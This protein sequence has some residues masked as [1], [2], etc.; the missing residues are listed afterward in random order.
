VKRSVPTLFPLYFFVILQSNLS[1]T[2][3]VQLME[4]NPYGQLQRLTLYIG[5]QVILEFGKIKCCFGFTKRL[6]RGGLG[7]K[8]KQLVHNYQLTILIN[9]IYIFYCA[10]LR[11]PFSLSRK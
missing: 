3:L 11:C 6:I 10:L 2:K 1:I 7:L 9:F 8:A 5:K 4:K